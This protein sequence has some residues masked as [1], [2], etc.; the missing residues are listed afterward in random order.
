MK[1]PLIDRLEAEIAAGRR[2]KA[3]E[4]FQGRIGS[5]WPGPAACERYGVL[6]AELED[7]VEAGKF[8]FLSGVRRPEYEDH[9]SL[10]L[11]RHGRSGPR[12]LAAQFPKSFRRQR[13][14]DLPAQLQTELIALGV[15]KDA[16][17]RR[18]GGTGSFR[19][20]PDWRSLSF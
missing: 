1:G 7:R 3:R 8:L 14:V 9:I 20:R 12:N 5:E 19:Q 10:F 16:F 4:L 2:W 15:R 13:F 17:G 11:S 18:Q 6:L